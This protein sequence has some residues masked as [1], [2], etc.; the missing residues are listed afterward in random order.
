[1][2]CVLLITVVSSFA[3]GCGLINNYVDP[4]GPRYE[5]RYAAAAAAVIP[6]TIKVVS[7][8]VKFAEAPEAAAE[9]LTSAPLA[10]ASIVLLQEMDAE[11]TDLIASALGMNYV[12]YP[13]SVHENGRDFGNAV[14]SRWP[15]VA[16]EK[17]ILPHRNPNN[18]QHRIA[19]RATVE[20]PAGLVDAYSVHTETIWLGLS[21][22][23]AQARTVAERTR[24]RRARIEV[25]GGDFN[26]SDPGS[27]DQTAEIFGAE[28]FLFA[29]RSV[30][31]TV[32]G[33]P[34]E[35]R[36]DHVFVR[37]VS[38]L[39]AGKRAETTASDHLPVWVDLE[40]D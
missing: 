22:R 15:I 38:P 14:L 8:N 20:T 2:R 19:V 21:A 18:G 39:D 24:A 30:G 5:G 37:N 31:R 25:V 12:Y 36:L 17:I 4:E 16:D 33:A 6:D 27:V 35:G 10:G 1:M 34:F 26:T 28:G 11:G 40:I 3:T 23:L 29:T 32:L 9:E 7:F 13:A